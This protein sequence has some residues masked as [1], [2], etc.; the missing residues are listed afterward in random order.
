MPSS[1]EDGDKVDIL[2]GTLKLSRKELEGLMDRQLLD[3]GVDSLMITHLQSLLSPQ[4]TLLELYGMPLGRVV[5]LLKLDRDS[6]AF[7]AQTIPAALDFS[8]FKLMEMQ[9]AYYIGRYESERFLPCQAYSEFDFDTL[10]ISLLEKALW[11]VLSIHPM[12]RARIVSGTL[13]QVLPFTTEDEQVRIPL[14]DSTDTTDLLTQR[15]EFCTTLKRHPD[16]FWKMEATRLADGRVRLRII[17]DMLFLDAASGMIIARDLCKA[18][19][20][21]LKGREPESIQI[22][23]PS[24]QE[25]CMSL[26]Q[27]S[28]TSRAYWLDKLETLPGPPGLPTVTVSSLEVSFQRVAMSLDP[29]TWSALKA[30]AR[31]LQVTPTALLLGAFAEVLRSFSHEPDFTLTLTVS[32]RPEPFANVVGDFTNVVYCTM[33]EGRDLKDRIQGVHTELAQALEHKDMS[34]LKVMRLLREKANDP[35]LSFP[36]VVTSLLGLDFG[37][38]SIGMGDSSPQ[39]HFQQTQTP[40]VW[41]DHQIYEMDGELR[42]NWDYDPMHYDPR[43]ME[44]MLEEFRSLL[45]RMSQSQDLWTEVSLS[46][47]PAVLELRERINETQRDLDTD[48][49]FLLHK[50]FK[51]EGRQSKVALVDQESSWTYG[52]VQAMIVSLANTLQGKGIVPGDIIAIVLEKGW[53]QVIR[54]FWAIPLGF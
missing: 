3:L 18:Y 7:I 5:T 24:F 39:L 28:E 13:Q 45:I 29:P 25:Y 10:D 21:L 38:D 4:P 34:G 37:S 35:Q 27:G 14:K 46:L 8:P 36:V 50:L 1:K 6:D 49:G 2:T 54:V 43:L 51:A 42:V 47:Q 22:Q 12:L 32:H 11:H 26:E 9:E 41:L 30:T 31:K 15:T 23:G 48:S 44:V 16:W 40:Q 17:F 52:E 53:E 20:Q 19:N 33:R